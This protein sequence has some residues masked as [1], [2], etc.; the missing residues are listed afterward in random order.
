[1]MRSW[2]VHG[3]FVEAFR[4]DFGR[5][6]TL[7]ELAVLRAV[8][9][10]AVANER[11]N[12]WKHDAVIERLHD[13]AERHQEA[14][15]E[16]QSWIRAEESPARGRT[17]ADL[18]AWCALTNVDHL[19]RETATTKARSSRPQLDAYVRSVPRARRYRDAGKTF[20]LQVYVVLEIFVL[21]ALAAAIVSTWLPS[22]TM[23]S[24]ASV[25]LALTPVAMIL[26]YGSLTLQKPWIVTRRAAEGACV[27]GLLALIGWMGG[28]DSLPAWQMGVCVF[29]VRY[30]RVGEAEVDRLAHHN[31]T[32][33]G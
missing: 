3:A 30:W 14:L 9:K 11:G 5:H 31:A 8:G 23:R 2:R 27:T 1:M 6:P 24:V 10:L 16:I 15:S 22:A 20:K 32:A 12:R 4:R 28:S 26:H 21:L 18:L 33:Q 13:L 25:S 19:L 7:D 17:L 29:V